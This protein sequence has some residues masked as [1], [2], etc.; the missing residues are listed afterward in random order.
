MREYDEIDLNINDYC[1]ITRIKNK[2]KYT[3]DKIARLR[4]QKYINKR[5]N[6][7]KFLINLNN[8]Y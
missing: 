8:G 6:L 1:E 7:T 2:S 5:N 3:M 4:E